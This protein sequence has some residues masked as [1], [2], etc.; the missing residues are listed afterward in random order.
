MQRAGCRFVD[1][2]IIGP[3]PVVRAKSSANAADGKEVGPAEAKSQPASGAAKSASAPIESSLPTTILLSGSTAAVQQIQRLFTSASSA[4]V[5]VD[6]VG[7]AVGRASAVKICHSAY[8]KGRQALLLNV[9]A[10]AFA[11]GVDEALANEWRFRCQG[12]V[13]DVLDAAKQVPPKAWRFVKEMEYIADTFDSHR[14][15]NDFHHGAAAVFADLAEFKGSAPGA[16]SL[17][18]VVRVLQRRKL[19]A[20]GHDAQADNSAGP[21]SNGAT[22]NGGPHA[23]PQ[24]D[25]QPKLRVNLLHQPMRATG[26]KVLCFHGWRTSGAILR[27]QCRDLPAVADW[28]FIDGFLPASG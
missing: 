2:A 4:M 25:S 15:N 6:H 18:E 12:L 16:L 23:A 1:G 14:L 8:H 20:K 27:Y 26:V 10:L 17:P 9:A 21:E 24:R 11:E 22:S 13:P 28:T 3:P 19:A 7:E 5:K